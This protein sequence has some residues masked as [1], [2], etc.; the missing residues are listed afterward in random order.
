[1]NEEEVAE[2]IL[3][4]LREHPHAMDTVEG[5][6]AWWLMRQQIKVSVRMLMNVLRRMTDE[7]L[8]EEVDAGETSRYRLR[9]E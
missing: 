8:L 9:Q 6:A 4:Y 1:M 5:I 2:A 7:G 3:D